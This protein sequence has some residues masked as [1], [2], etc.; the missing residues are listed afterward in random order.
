MNRN[1]KIAIG[2][3][4][5]GCLGLIVTA[6]IGLGAYFYF[7]SVQPPRSRSSNI[8]I[9]S[10]RSSN[11]NSSN[12]N[13]SNSNSANSTE[14][15]PSSSIPDDTKH[16]LFHA[17]GMTQDSELQARVLR[18]IGFAAETGSSYEEF[19]KDHIAWTVNNYEFILSVN[20]PAKARAYVEA[21]IN[22]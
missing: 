12:S 7:E 3:G 4:G 17:V 18:K 6:A 15:P 16:K 21:H 20:T 2:C 10:N 9:N 5:A 1:Q 8:N 19:V 13:S 22:D 11:N 14:D